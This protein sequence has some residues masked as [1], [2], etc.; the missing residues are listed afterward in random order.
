MNKMHRLTIQI[1]QDQYEYIKEDSKEGR[2]LSHIIRVALDNWINLQ[3]AVE[4]EQFERYRE[5]VVND[6]KKELFYAKNSHS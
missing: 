4:A 3:E 5:Y 2:S 1:R 6:L